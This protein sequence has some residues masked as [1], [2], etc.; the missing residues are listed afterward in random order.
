MTTATHCPVFER[1]YRSNPPVRPVRVMRIITR[2]NVGGPSYQA[3][4][5]TQRLRGPEFAST[6]L[7]GTIGTREGSLEG[8]AAEREV[9]VTRIPGLGREISIRSDGLTVGRLFWEIRRFQPDIVHTHMAKAGAVGRLAAKLARV[10]TI[11][12][13][14]HGHVFHG[15]FSPRKTEL[16]LRV[17][18]L[19][20][21]WTD[22]IVVLGAAQEQ[23]I[24]GF[25]VGRPE[26]MVRIPLGL[27][28]EPFL[29][30][31][32]HRGALRRELGIR[33]ET[34]LV[35]IVARLVP[36]KAHD[37]FLEAARRVALSRPETRFVIIGDGELRD[38]LEL[39]ARSLGFE[40]V[41]HAAGRQLSAA[42]RPPL[43]APGSREPRARVHFLGLRSDLLAIYADLDVVV[44]CSRSEGLPVTIIEALAAAR[45]VVATEVGAVRDL[46]VPGRTG[47]LVRSGEAAGLAEAILRQLSDRPAAESMARRGRQRVYPHLSIDRL[48]QEIRQLYVGLVDRAA[49]ADRA[50]RLP[51]A[52]RQPTWRRCRF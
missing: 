45:P 14:Y 1:Q 33:P 19:L 32:Q 42:R 49:A 36:I 46:V 18:R 9:S 29:T 2:L 15:Y 3:I 17:E 4:Y 35:G 31:E 41:S 13:T 5:L 52:A 6:L 51:A 47:L 40:V 24:L 25:G 37:L 34:P 11:V 38:R 26:Q 23:E 30:V 20:A 7:T 48:E 44:L 39:Q 27:E 10:P 50:V 8:L 12:H 22:R 16:I 43:P 21:Q 28:L